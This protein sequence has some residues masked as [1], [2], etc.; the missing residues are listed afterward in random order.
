MHKLL[1][2]LPLLALAGCGSLGQSTFCDVYRSCGGD[3]TA[4]APAEPDGSEAGEGEAGEG[5][6]GESGE[7]SE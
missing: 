6:A 7:A 5:E 3:A 1:Y 2:A 4:P